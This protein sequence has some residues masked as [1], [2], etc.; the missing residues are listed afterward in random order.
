[1]F[2][3]NN[4]N[5]D[6]E[7]IKEA[8]REP[9]TLHTE[10]YG[11]EEKKKREKPRHMFALGSVF[12]VVGERYGGGRNEVV[13]VGRQMKEMGWQRAMMDNLNIN[14]TDLFFF[15]TTTVFAHS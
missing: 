10:I 4:I 5:K 9:H 7:I 12:M 14:I 3:N 6:D 2:H 8:E 15:S 13:H 1:M 11:S